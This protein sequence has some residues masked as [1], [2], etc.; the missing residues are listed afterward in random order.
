[1][2]CL[3]FSGSERY[4]FEKAHRVLF[5]Y[6]GRAIYLEACHGVRNLAFQFVN[7]C[8]PLK[9]VNLF[10]L[11]ILG[12][13]VVAVVSEHDMPNAVKSLTQSTRKTMTVT[14]A[15]PTSTIQTSQRRRF[16]NYS[17]DKAGV[18]ELSL[19]VLGIALLGQHAN[20]ACLPQRP[21]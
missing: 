15:V 10:K 13:L 8:E 14:S 1:M 3:S 4:T 20:R 12:P 9:T 17:F 7:R 18:Q 21:P 6:T 19:V 16:G 5:K 2:W 11:A